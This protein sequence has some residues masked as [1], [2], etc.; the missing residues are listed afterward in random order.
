M[1][2][3]KKSAVLQ[4]IYTAAVPLLLLLISFPSPATAKPHVVAT[5][6]ALAQIAQAVGGIDIHVKSLTSIGHDPNVFS[7]RPGHA[8][9][10]S[11]AL[12]LF[13]VG[14]GLESSWLPSL[15]KR[16]GNSKIIPGSDGYFSGGDAI[17]AI[18]VPRGMSSQQISQWSPD[19]NPY[20]WLDPE[21]GIKVAHALAVRLSELD[22]VNAERYLQRASEFEKAVK[23]KLPVWRDH[24]NIHTGVVITYHNT[25]VYFMEAMNIELGGFIE[26]RSGIEPSTRYMDDLLRVIREKNVKLIWVEPYNNRAIAKRL[27]GAAG[28]KMMILPDAVEGYGTEGYIGMFDL[29]VERVARWS[30]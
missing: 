26:P 29:M 15:I 4:S 10:L 22:A 13:S 8:R 7:P 27:A 28:I 3:L 20:W 2:L 25:Y 30:Q 11:S 24:M 16:S 18:G 23:E 21:M 19:K 17:E 1:S 5:V 9:A 14:F 12:L 6:P